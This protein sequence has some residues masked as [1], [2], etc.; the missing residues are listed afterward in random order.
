MILF[1]K[2]LQLYGMILESN[3]KVLLLKQFGACTNLLEK[4]GTG[5]LNF[6]LLCLSLSSYFYTPIERI[7]GLLTLSLV[8]YGCDIRLNTACV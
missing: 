8:N 6:K 5:V 2:G 3:S 4:S 1:C 7:I